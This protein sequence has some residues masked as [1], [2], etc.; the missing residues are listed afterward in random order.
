MIE[1]SAL[2]DIVPV[3]MASVI[4]QRA[5]R[6]PFLSVWA[7]KDFTTRVPS[8]MSIFTCAGIGDFTTPG[9]ATVTCTGSTAVSPRR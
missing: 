1:A 8:L 6:L 5:R 4:F 7:A 2:A 3:G 9:A